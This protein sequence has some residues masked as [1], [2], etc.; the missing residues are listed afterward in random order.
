MAGYFHICLSLV[1]R[2]CV[3]VGGGK[4]A[5]RKA[6]S[7]VE[8][9][10][11][12][13]IVSPRFCPELSELDGVELLERHFADAD[14]EGATLVVAATDDPE[15]NRT[16]ARAA[17]K[18]GALVNVV[19]TPELCDFIVPATVRRGDLVLAISTSSKAPALAKRL[20]M[21]LE[22]IIPDDY[23]GFVEL[24]GRLRPQVLREVADAAHRTQV[25]HRLASREAWELF[26]AEGPQALQDLADQLVAEAVSRRAGEPHR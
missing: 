20:R 17:R 11:H 13:A 3:V 24:L 26:A 2:R 21:E 19:D 4:V 6:R 12:V 10:A 23:A 8:A 22:E 14:L 16:I 7:L 15:L 1:G 18:T 5:C 9:D 25:F